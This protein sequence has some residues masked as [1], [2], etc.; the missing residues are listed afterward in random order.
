MCKVAATFRRTL[1]IAFGGSLTRSMR[2]KESKSSGRARN[3]QVEG[4][5]RG[6]D[7]DDGGGDDDDDEL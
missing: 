4:S 5:H 3:L 7:D 2:K 6:S 1:S